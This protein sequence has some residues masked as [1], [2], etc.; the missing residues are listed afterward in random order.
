M[1]KETVTEKENPELYRLLHRKIAEKK[2]REHNFVWCLNMY[3]HDGGLGESIR[4]QWNDDTLKDYLSHYENIIIPA[5][6][7]TAFGLNDL[8]EMTR[9]DLEDVLYEIGRKRQLDNE[10]PYSD[11]YMNHFRYIIWLVYKSGFVNNHYEDRLGFERIGLYGKKTSKI[12]RARLMVLKKSLTM[13][14]ERRMA[15]WFKNNLKADSPGEWYGI[16]L[17]FTMGLRNAEACGVAFKNIIQLQ[18]RTYSC[19]F[20]TTALDSEG[21]RKVGGK[22]NNMPRILPIYDTVRDLIQTRKDEIVRRLSAE[23]IRD[24]EEVVDKYPIACRGLD[25]SMNANSSDLTEFGGDLLKK[26]L[27]NDGDSEEEKTFEVRRELVSQELFKE[28][29][30]SEDVDE[31]DSTTYLFRRNFASGLFGLGFTANQCHYLMGHLIDDYSDLRDYY[32]NPDRQDDLRAVFNKHPLRVFFG[33]KIEFVKVKI[34]H[35]MKKKDARI[36]V[37]SK[38]PDDPIAVRSCGEHSGVIHAESSKGFLPEYS[39]VSDIR[40]KLV[41]V[42]EKVMEDSRDVDSSRNE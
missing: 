5:M 12:S 36:E 26:I 29:L 34:D 23:G 35:R 1:S 20:I 2:S 6:D 21:K 7:R 41:E 11:S 30:K 28:R 13:E 9:D 33:E 18:G 15:L 37:Y 4:D 17:M 39:S 42:A 14:E 3:L 19:A 38:E 25:F 22:T 32:A 24:P 10:E 8:S 27:C 16:L 31:K 40:T